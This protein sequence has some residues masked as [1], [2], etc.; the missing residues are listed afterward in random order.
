MPHSHI[1]SYAHRSASTLYLSKVIRH[2]VEATK[3][4]PRHQR[5]RSHSVAQ[6]KRSVRFETGTKGEETQDEPLISNGSGR[7]YAEGTVFGIPTSQPVQQEKQYAFNKVETLHKHRKYASLYHNLFREE[8]TDVPF[9]VDEL[10]AMAQVQKAVKSTADP[11][12]A[13][14]KSTAMKH[15]MAFCKRADLPVWLESNST[16]TDRAA[17]AQGE[18]FMLYEVATFDIKA[19]SVAAKLATVGREHETRRMTDPFA[20]NVMLKHKIKEMCKLDGPPQPK[21]PVTDATLATLKQLLDLSKRPSL[22]LWVGLRFAIALL[23]RIS[24][25][26]FNEKHAV[27]WRCIIF[28]DEDHNEIHL[29]S[30]AQL[31]Q[32]FEMEVLF[33]S[34][35][36]HDFGQGTARSFFAIPD[37]SDGRCIVRDVALLW[38]LSEREKSYQVFSW[39]HN[40]R[41][42]SRQDV[43]TVLKQAAI[44]NGIPA[45]DIASHS[46]RISGLS[47]LLAAGMPYEFARAYGRWRSDCARRYW[48]PETK[49]AQDY[50]SKLWD[51]ALFARIRGGGGVQYL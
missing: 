38:L 44:L 20:N 8:L 43:S 10:S 40:T 36:T 16:E 3:T 4:E 24:E 49:M 9:S 46:L 2:I 50:S 13:A 12:A 42:P 18:L 1:W 19:G 26:G 41:G 48:W 37:T 17:S 32:I 30:I 39:D 15:W 25:W 27:T 28:Y 51:P 47:R 5:V 23:C 29:H 21:I 34:D 33:Y 22:V 31:Y 7:D 35:K 45:A 6:A 14:A 11:K